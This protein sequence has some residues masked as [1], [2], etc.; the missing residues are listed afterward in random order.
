MT[1]T[2][3]KLYANG[4][5]GAN[6]NIQLIADGNKVIW[7]ANKVCY[8]LMWRTKRST[9]ATICIPLIECNTSA[10]VEYL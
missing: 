3:G 9:K 5:G 1:G 8:H 10:S 4:F 6:A 2:P 7:V